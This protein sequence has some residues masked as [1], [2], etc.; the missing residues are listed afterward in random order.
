ML[1]VISFHSSLL[2]LSAPVYSAITFAWRC[3]HQRTSLRHKPKHLS[4]TKSSITSSPL[5]TFSPRSTEAPKLSKE[6]RRKSP[7]NILRRNLDRCSHLGDVAEALRLYDAARDAS[8]PLSLHHYNV[9]LYLCSH[10][11]ASSSDADRALD[12]FRQMS[13]DGIEPNEATYSTL[14]RVAATRGDPDQAYEFIKTMLASGIT[15]RLRTYSPA[16]F[17]FCD[18]DDVDKAHELEDLMVTSGVAA[19]EPELAVL[20]RL[21]SRL[22]R[23]EDVYRLL[24]KLRLAVRKVSETTAEMIEGWFSSDAAAGVGVEDWDV[25]KVNEGVVEGGGGW[26]GQGW[27]GKGKWSVARSEMDS[28]GVCRRCRERMVCIDIDPRETEV[29]ARSLA[30]LSCKKVAKADFA[31]F[32]EWLDQHGPFDAVIDGANVGLN[33]QQEFSFF[34]LNSIANGIRNRIRGRL[35]DV[36]RNTKLLESWRQAGALYSTPPGSN[37]DWY[38]L[39]AAVRF[40]CLVVTN[41]EMRDHLFALLGNNFF[42]RWKEKHQ[43]RFTASCPGPTFYM[44]PP[45]SIVI[46]ESRDGSWHIPTI[47]GDDIDAPRQWICA[48][49]EKDIFSIEDSS[50]S[51]HS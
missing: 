19:E 3:R 5:S 37:D 26:H 48:K 23:G 21:N 38:W 41:D 44:P 17:G 27:L 8:T 36:P 42:P 34:Q 20:F 15:P 30:E 7:E 51:I 32:Q 6:A 4:F 24:H 43:V 25:E 31:R 33:K 11:S 35:A 47:I 16:L 46:Q 49:R 40:K 1:A 28:Q 22:G 29:F 50:P 39:Y 10:P 9:L 2:R 13:R 12:I 18:I 14:V 45:Y